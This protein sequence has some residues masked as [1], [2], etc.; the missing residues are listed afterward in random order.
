MAF[1]PSS[2]IYGEAPGFLLP[3][4][5]NVAGL[6]NSAFTDTLMNNTGAPP[7]APAHNGGASTTGASAAPVTSAPDLTLEQFR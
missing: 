3:E 2:S 7:T 1:E 4:V 5:G 6:L